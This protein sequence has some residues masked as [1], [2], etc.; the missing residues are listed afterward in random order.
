MAGIHDVTEDAIL[1][2]LFRAVTWSG[3]ASAVGSETNIGIALHTA[4]PGDAGNASTSEI[5]TGAYAGYT[6]VNVAR[7]TGGW[8]AS[9][10]CSISPAANIDFP[11]GTGGT[12]ATATN[13]STSSSS[14]SPPTGA[15]AI[16]WSGAISPSIVC[17]NGV[18]PRLT[19]ATTITLT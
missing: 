15:A 17:G 3:Y 2:L 4:D 13:W 5:T 1:N 10:G 18:T 8:S 16:L 19:T 7:S 14:G 11:A 6:R 12:G 9:S